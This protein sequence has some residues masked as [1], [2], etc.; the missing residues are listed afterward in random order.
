MKPLIIKQAS[1]SK[2]NKGRNKTYQGPCQVDGRTI[3]IIERHNEDLMGNLTPPPAPSSS[4]LQC[5]DFQ[6]T[7]EQQLMFQSDSSSAISCGSEVPA[8][9]RGLQCHRALKSP[10]ITKVTY[11]Y[12]IMNMQAGYDMERFS[13]PTCCNMETA[14][15]PCG[16]L[17]CTEWK[18]IQTREP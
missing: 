12:S 2:P 10:T 1:R 8:R 3:K 18:A 11:S 6:D 5:G 17:Q 9:S 13:S 16:E 14:E 7:R 15:G 4:T